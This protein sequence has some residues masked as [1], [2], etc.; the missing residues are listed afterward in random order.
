VSETAADHIAAAL[1]AIPTVSANI[2]GT[3]VNVE[4]GLA[5][6]DVGQVR[7]CIPN[8]GSVMPFPGD[9]VRLLRINQTTLLLGPVAQRATLGRVVSTSGP[10]GCLVEYPTGSG[11]TADMGYPK[12]SSPTIGDICLIDWASGGTVAAFITYSPPPPPPPPPLPPP[13]AEPETTVFTATDSGTFYVPSRRWSTRE[14][15]A[16]TTGNNIGAWFYGSKIA[17]T[18]PDDA[19][20]S[21]VQIYGPLSYNGGSAAVLQCHSH[22]TKPHSAVALIGET[23]TL[24][25]RSGWIPLPVQIGDWLRNNIGGIAL[26]GGG[27]AKYRGLDTDGQSGALRITYG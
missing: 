9:S 16:V 5:V 21:S 19:P 17:D 25:P 4:A 15:W 26:V 14:V 12:N 6:V 8:V 24:N 10:T 2:I 20:I 22:Q 7:I 27:W 3:F 1:A 13:P 11:V 18:I 23:V